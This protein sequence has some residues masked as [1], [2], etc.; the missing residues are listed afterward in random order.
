MFQ[1]HLRL[2]HSGPKHSYLKLLQKGLLKNDVYQEKTVQLLQDLHQKLIMHPEPPLTIIKNQMEEMRMKNQ[3][4]QMESPDFA[5]IQDSEKTFLRLMGEW[6][7][8]RKTVHASFNVKGL[9]G[10][11]MYGSVGTG[12][13]MLS[14]T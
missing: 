8:R 7:S 5:W 4:A 2:L 14:K 13:T 6:F 11:Y 10:L 1:L 3:G 12:K 9:K